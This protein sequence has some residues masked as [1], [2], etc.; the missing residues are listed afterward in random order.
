MFEAFGFRNNVFCWFH[1]L[2][3][4]EILLKPHHETP[5]LSADYF[6]INSLSG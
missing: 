6:G 3:T 4:F 5:P 1:F 2:S